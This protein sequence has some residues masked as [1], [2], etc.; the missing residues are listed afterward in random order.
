MKKDK[1]IIYILSAI[2]IFVIVF[3]ISQIYHKKINNKIYNSSS[4]DLIIS[5]LDK[6]N[7]EDILEEFN[8]YDEFSYNAYFKGSEAL[9]EAAV[10]IDDKIIHYS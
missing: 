7:K 9:K 10:F 2:L 6:F 3:S 5:K 1:I 4:Q 8:T